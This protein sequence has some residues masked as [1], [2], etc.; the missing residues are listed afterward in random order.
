MRANLF[1][2]LMA[3]YLA[4]TLVTLIAVGFATSQ[5]LAN[6]F[7]TSKQH[8]LE[9]KGQELALLVSAYL[10][11]NPEQPIDPMLVTLGHFLNARVLLVDKENLQLASAGVP[12]HP[13]LWLTAGEAERIL[14]GE[15]ISSRGYHKRFQEAVLSVTVPVYAQ[16]QVAGALAIAA[17][18]AGLTAT[19]N[20]IRSLILY[21]AAAAVV[22]SALVGTWLSRSISRPLSQ[23]SRITREM[24]KG[25]FDQRIEVT[26]SDEVGQLAQDFN[27]LAESLD[28]TVTA[29]FR[30]KS[31]I[32]S[33]LAHMAEGV[34]AVDGQGQVILANTAISR[35][36]AVKPEDII[37][38][39]LSELPFSGIPEVFASVT[40]SGEPRSAELD[41]NG[42]KTCV[43]IHVAPLTNGA[44]KISG[45]VGVL[46]DITDIKN[47]E[48][49]RRDLVAN[50]SHELRTP[51]TSIRGFIE[52]ILDGTIS[53]PEAQ[54]HYLKVIH[55]ETVRLT[56]L[57][58]ELLDLA[59]MEAGKI[60]WEL[61]PIE[62]SELVSR[63][64][65]KLGPQLEQHQISVK[66]DI[67]QSLPLM[68][69]NEDRMEQVLT[70]LVENAIR[71]SPPGKTVTVKAGSDKGLVQIEVSDEGPGIPEED[72]PY[73][74]D[75]FHRVEK[76]RSR[77][78]GGTGLGL[79]IVKQI[80]EA[81][82]GKV[83]VHSQPGQGSTFFF[84]IPAVPAEN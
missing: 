23:M 62:V 67:S 25:N 53:D 40:D 80:V 37:N 59:Q 39:P 75:R 10:E 68:L 36:L 64:L 35:T 34:L 38:R 66:V 2:K 1:T 58:R 20:A 27:Y 47:L 50:V 73:I 63:V 24:A 57:I 78:L 52:A 44:G 76:S 71:Y 79:A 30:E 32:E 43:L 82:G 16:D 77:S 5:L 72:L 41:L 51:L 56:R 54:R 6:Y 45:A 46:Q 65:F 19:I 26:T 60:V 3:S 42:G 31:K 18:I 14:N 28:A 70:N 55:Q 4:I 15:T 33:I 84:S 69:A 17:P 13:P 81:H 83:G 21:A 11:G 49:W 22:L 7:Y 12:L 8:E 48:V 61:H 74:W 29:L 9:R